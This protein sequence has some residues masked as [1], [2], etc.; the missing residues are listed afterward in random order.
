VSH[1]NY[2]LMRHSDGTLAVHEVYYDEAGDVEG[3][4]HEPTNFVGETRQ[5]VHNA[6]QWALQDIEAPVLDWCADDEL[7]DPP[8]LN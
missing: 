3:W 7:D 8:V 2:R 4:A 5:D 1:W 6:L